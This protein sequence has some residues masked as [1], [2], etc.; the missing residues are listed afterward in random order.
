MSR[1]EENQSMPQDPH[2]EVHQ[3]HME[4]EVDVGPHTSKE[5]QTSPAPTANTTEISEGIVARA[6]EHIQQ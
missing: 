1:R 4:I 2:V 5:M 6:R 3:A